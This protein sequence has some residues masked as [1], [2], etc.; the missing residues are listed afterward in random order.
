MPQ[1]LKDGQV[2]YTD[3]TPQTLDQYG[4]DVA[5][6]LMWAAEPKL[7]E[8]NRLGFQVMIF[9]IVFTGLL[10]FTKK[11]VWHDVHHDAGCF[12][13]A[14]TQRRANGIETF[15]RRQRRL[16]IKSRIV[17]SMDEAQARSGRGAVR[18]CPPRALARC[19]RRRGSPQC[20]RA[21]CAAFAEGM[22]LRR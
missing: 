15:V 11:K 9:L 14:R 19:A 7:D 18:T 16:G 21:P 6:F 5:A 17:Q 22:R 8:R 13:I 3:G 20:W 12:V 1:P 2:K 4:R 10:Y